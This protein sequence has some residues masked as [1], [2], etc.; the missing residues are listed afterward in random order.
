MNKKAFTL[1]ELLA[2][3][4]IIGILSAIALPQYHK[5]MEKAHFTKAQVMAKSLYDS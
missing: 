3:I 1:L 4:T 5:V 2:V